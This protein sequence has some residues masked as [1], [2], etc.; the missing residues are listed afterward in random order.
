MRSLLALVFSAVLAACASTSPLQPDGTMLGTMTTGPL[1]L[2]TI[3]GKEMRLAPGARIMGANN[4]SVT[5]NQ[6]APNS[7]VRYR[8]DA[9]TGQVTQVWLLPA[10]K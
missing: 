3:D 6:V 1:P 4:A 10:S 2:V 8:V 5:P 7:P 9:T